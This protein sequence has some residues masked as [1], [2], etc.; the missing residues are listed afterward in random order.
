MSKQN[1]SANKTKGAICLVIEPF[2]HFPHQKVNFLY[3]SDII[4]NKATKISY[5]FVRPQHQTT[6]TVKLVPWIQIGQ[7]NNHWRCD[8]E[9]GSGYVFIGQD[10]LPNR[11]KFLLRVL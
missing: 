2:L 6:D 4:A 11:L 9:E 10:S 1:W 5:G 8:I 3:R 7:W